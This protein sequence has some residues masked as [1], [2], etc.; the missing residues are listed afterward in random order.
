M[1]TY[2][3]RYISA[4]VLI[5][6]VFGLWLSLSNQ[7]ERSAVPEID[8]ICTLDHVV[9]GDTIWVKCL[10]GFKEGQ[11]FKV[12]LAE[13]DAPEMDTKEGKESKAFLERLL[14]NQTYLFLNIDEEYTYDRYGRVIAIV[15]IPLDLQ[16]GTFLNVNYYL[17]SNDMA[18]WVDYRNSWHP[19]EFSETTEIHTFI[20]YPEQT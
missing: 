3:K 8:S 5:L 16:H 2:D 4:G 9:D 17:V 18:E 19:E 14:V 12:R 20:K 13:I 1:A 6:F 11:R 7:E 10:V 15:Y